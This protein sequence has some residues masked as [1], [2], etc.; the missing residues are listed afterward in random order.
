MLR[1]LRSSPLTVSLVTLTL[2]ACSAPEESEQARARRELQPGTPGA[3]NLVAENLQ[4]SG[5][6]TEAPPA[7][8]AGPLPWQQ[9]RCGDESLLVIGDEHILLQRGETQWQLQA[10]EAASGARYQAAEDNG[11]WFWNK[12][13]R[14]RLSIAGQEFPECVADAEGGLMP[15]ELS[16]LAGGR[17]LIQRMGNDEVPASAGAYLQFGA[18]G[19]LTG[20]SGCNSFQG[21]YGPGRHEEALRFS[22]LASTLKACDEAATLRERNLHQRLTHIS[23]FHLPDADTL[24]LSD[25]Q[26]TLLLLK[27]QR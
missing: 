9:F 7:S 6:N 25:E 15:A 2:I 14:A 23:R 10:S 12:G 11:T 19:A 3:G 1:F 13:E 5:I 24:R 16:A 27:R 26:A 8:D 20:A 4:A 17:W 22:T 18:N 21:R